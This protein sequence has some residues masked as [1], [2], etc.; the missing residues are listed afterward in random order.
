MEK[1][2]GE[3]LDTYFIKHPDQLPALRRQYAEIIVK[4]HSLQWQSMKLT[5]LTPPQHEKAHAMAEIQRYEAVMLANQYTPQPLMAEIFNWLK[6]NVPVADRTT[7]C[8]GDLKV[9]VAGNFFADDGQITAL[10]D[11]ELVSIGDPLSDLGYVSLV[12]QNRLFWDKEEFLQTYETLTDTQVNRESLFF[13]EV[14]TYVKWIVM[15]YPGFKSGLTSGDHDVRALA[16][17]V[18]FLPWLKNEAAVKLGI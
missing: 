2:R 5:S 7:L 1:V 3:N 12:L 6:K 15:G 10:L 9:G 17:N 13:W 18:A 8:H 14:M 16:T 11:W 4:L